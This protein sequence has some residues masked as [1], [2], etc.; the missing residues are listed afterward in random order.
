MTW[1]LAIFLRP[2]IAVLFL[3][4]ILRPLRRA[5]WKRIPNGIVKRILFISWKV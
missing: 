5:A 2:F 3:W 1:A 4:L